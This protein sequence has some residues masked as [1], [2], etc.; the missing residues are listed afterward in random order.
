MTSVMNDSSSR[1]GISTLRS[2]PSRAVLEAVT[3]GECEGRSRAEIFDAVWRLA[4]LGS[5]HNCEDP[6]EAASGVPH[7][8]EPWFC[9]AE[10][11]AVRLGA[12]AAALKSL[13]SNAALTQRVPM[14]AGI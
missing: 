8:L 5:R 1:G 11:P 9:Y 4:G 12:P 3:P 2:A 10:P 13:V 14:V 7:L 6:T